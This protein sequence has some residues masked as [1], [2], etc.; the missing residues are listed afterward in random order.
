LIPFLLNKIPLATLAA[1][2]ILVGWKLAKPA[3]FVGFWK[4]GKYQ[5]IPFITTVVVI[6]AIDLFQ[7]APAL[8]GKGLIIGVFA[9][10]IAATGAILHGNLK[11]SYYFHKEKHK[12]GDLINIKLSEEVS[13]LNKA[14]IRQTLDHM[15]KNSSVRLDASNTKYIDYDVLELIKE[16][17]DIKAPLK[18]IQLELVGFKEAYNIENSLNVQ[19]VH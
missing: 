14:A 10:I 9:G 12:E 1:I 7:I 8:S 6:L 17:R 2:L 13:F 15:P 5:F 4:A 3:V 18:N 19:S 16:F 11:N